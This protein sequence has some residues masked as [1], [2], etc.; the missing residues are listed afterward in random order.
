MPFAYAMFREDLREQN[1]NPD[2]VAQWKGKEDSPHRK[3]AVNDCN[4]FLREE[5]FPCETCEDEKMSI[6]EKYEN[7][8]QLDVLG[9]KYCSSRYFDIQ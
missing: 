8:F 7:N 9:E 2:I 4:R 6:I 3:M 1:L 5:K